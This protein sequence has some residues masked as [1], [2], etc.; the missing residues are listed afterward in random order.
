MKLGDYRVKRNRRVRLDDWDTRDDGGLTKEEAQP[1]LAGLQEELA[2]WQERLYAEGKQSLLVVLQARDA[3][4]KDGTV[5]KVIGAF[6]PNGVRVSNFKVPTSE[7]K[8]HD[9]LRRIHAQVPRAG[10]VGVFNRSHYEDVLVPLVHGE[11]D[12]E[13]AEERLKDIRHFEALLGRSGTRIVKF[14]LHV[15]ADEQKERLQARLD[16][17][18]KHWKFN[19]GDLAERALWDGYTDA[20]EACLGT[21]TDAAPWYVVPA[22]RKWFRDL[23]VSRVL[24]HTLK[25]MDPQYPA[26]DFDPGAIVIE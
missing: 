19:P 9:F 7:E 1:L 10:M 14:Y 11:M 6:N 23:L 12:A 16:D 24:L 15:S 2:D 3:G 4:G 8:A 26:V 5:K 21:S 22:D 18:S 25:D 20:Y 13:A 17:P